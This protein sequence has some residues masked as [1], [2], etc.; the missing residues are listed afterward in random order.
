MIVLSVLCAIY[1]PSAL[2]LDVIVV[3]AHTVALKLVMGK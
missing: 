2:I 1:S 3:Y